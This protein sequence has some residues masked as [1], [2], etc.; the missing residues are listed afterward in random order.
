M[1]K[2]KK[3]ISL[4][5]RGKVRH[6]SNHFNM[7]QLVCRKAK[8]VHVFNSSEASNDFSF[9]EYKVCMVPPVYHM[10]PQGPGYL[11]TD[12]YNQKSRRA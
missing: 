3:A 9:G 4:E 6:V 1:R 5:G 2:A 7:Q 8:R 10:L 11:E 12:L